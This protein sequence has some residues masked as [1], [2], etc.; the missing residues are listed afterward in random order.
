MKNWKFAF[1]NAYILLLIPFAV[2]HAPVDPL[3]I[4]II[5]VYVTHMHAANLTT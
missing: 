3:L 2:L 5:F 4:C 1:E